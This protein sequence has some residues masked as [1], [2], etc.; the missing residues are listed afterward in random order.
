[1][2]EEEVTTHLVLKRG[3]RHQI[4]AHLA[5]LG[6]PIIGDTVYNPNHNRITSNPARKSL[7]QQQAKSMCLFACQLSFF[8]PITKKDMFISVPLHG[9]FT[10]HISDLDPV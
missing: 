5:Y 8:H 2:E 10:P 3:Y 6:L 1:M 9:I 4:R 7:E